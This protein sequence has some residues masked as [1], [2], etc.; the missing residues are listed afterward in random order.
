MTP[1]DDL[2]PGATPPARPGHPRPPCRFVGREAPI[3]VRATGPDAIRAGEA[4]W[5][6]P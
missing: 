1:A 2:S 3:V 4:G 6:A 5:P